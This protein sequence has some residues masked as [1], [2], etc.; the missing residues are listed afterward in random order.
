[1]K[2]STVCKTT[3]I[4]TLLT[5]GVSGGVWAASCYEQVINKKYLCTTRYENGGS[6]S[7]SCAR[8]SENIT[9]PQKPILLWAGSFDYDCTC[10]SKG[11]FKDPKFNSDNEILCIGV[12]HHDGF[13]AK[14]TDGGKKIKS[15]EYHDSLSNTSAVFE[16]EEDLAC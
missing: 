6:P 16:C 14:V 3:V 10:L 5:V 7:A 8:F 1:M 15:G 11:N 13:T 4:T 2:F 9:A 12:N